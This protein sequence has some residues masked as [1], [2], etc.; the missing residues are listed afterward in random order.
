MSFVFARANQDA[1][2]DA[3]YQ[4]VVLAITELTVPLAGPA[5]ET[6][7]TALK[8]PVDAGTNRE[9]NAGVAIL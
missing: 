4:Q 7:S 9:E 1:A 2:R 5:N 8:F 3:T 6:L